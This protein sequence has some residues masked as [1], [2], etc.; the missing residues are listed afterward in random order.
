MRVRSYLFASV[1]AALLAA[2]AAVSGPAGAQTSSAELATAARTALQSGDNEAAIIQYSEAIESRKLPPDQL[3]D[4]LMNRGYA[5]Q[6]TG[7]DE[8][9]IDDYTAALQID[10]LS[11]RMRAMA[12]YNRGLSYQKTKEPALA[13]EDFTSALYLD[14]EF[15][16]AYYMRGSVLR[17]NGQ[18]LFALS[19]FD[20]A[21]LYNHPQAHLVRY[22][23]ALAY[24]MLK[25]PANAKA[26]LLSALKA[27][28]SYAPARVRLAAYGI[29][30]PAQPVVAQMD[31]D[32]LVTGSVTQANDDQV[33][34][35][36]TLPAAVKPPAELASAGEYQT[37][38]AGETV[39]AVEKTAKVYT[40][41]V[42]EEDTDGADTAQLSGAKKEKPAAKSAEKVVAIEALP[43]EPDA[44]IEP[45]SAQPDEDDQ[46]SAATD[47][48]APTGWGVQIFSAVD[49]KIAWNMW[50]KIK[51]KHRMLSD[52]K[53]VVV[54]ADLGTKGIVFRL[55]LAGF[56]DK[57][58]AQ[59]MCGKL[60]SRGVSCFVSKFDS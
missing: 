42:P 8:D 54:K 40:D 44:K 11:P 15:A 24:E 26:S 25:Q 17:E 52:Q 16:H 58:D 27:N 35:K 34:R 53:A 4:A 7:H 23:Q 3:A 32:T 50:D 59:S 30:A 33:V 1:C 10:A 6:K 38:S 22:A 46:P 41:R 36:E 20:K 12:L 45:A 5:N 18:Y 47:A 56:D 37:A 29:S 57:S 51:A 13:I 2:P 28:P 19:D 21:L 43:D 55:R 14:P 60:K 48:P 31:A 49:E 39:I 9:A